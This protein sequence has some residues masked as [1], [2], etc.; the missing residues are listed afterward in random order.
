MDNLNKEAERLNVQYP[1][2]VHPLPTDVTKPEQVQSLEGAARSFADR[3]DFV[4]NNVGIGMTL[5]TEKVTFD[6]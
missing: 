1:G 2:K 4:F 6:L 5:P 3:L